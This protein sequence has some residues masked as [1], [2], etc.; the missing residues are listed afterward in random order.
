MSPAMTPDAIERLARKR[1]AR[2]MGWYIHAF[3]YICVNIGLALLSSFTGQSWAIFP[4]L[5]W[6]LGLLIHGLVVFVAPPGSGFQERLV[7][8]ERDRL[9]QQQSKQQTR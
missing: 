2:K 8:Q 1:A 9:Q 6:G 3:V 7:Q 4:A 5:G